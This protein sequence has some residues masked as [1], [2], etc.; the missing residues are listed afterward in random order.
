MIL[1][2]LSMNPVSGQ[3]QQKTDHLP[4]KDY[5]LIDWVQNHQLL[6]SKG[7]CPT[8]PGVHVYILGLNETRLVRVVKTK[9]A[10]HPF[11]LKVNTIS[12]IS[13]YYMATIVRTLWLA[14]ERALFSCNDQA[15]W[16]FFSARRL[17]WVVSKTMCALVKTTENMDKIQLYFQQLKEKLAY[18]Y[19]FSMSDEKS[20]SAPKRI[21]E[22]NFR[23]SYCILFKNSAKKAI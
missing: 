19:F 14:T 3:V 22:N 16:N 15:L 1:P 2:K 13:F 17:F 18:R 4:V 10:H 11:G 5:W 6:F 8:P 9:Q 21:F 23:C 20:R 7:G 12:F